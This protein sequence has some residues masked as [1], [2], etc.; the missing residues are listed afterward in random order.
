MIMIVS[1]STNKADVINVEGVEHNNLMRYYSDMA[2]QT[3]F[4]DLRYT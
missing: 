4:Y 1:V 3:Y 2:R